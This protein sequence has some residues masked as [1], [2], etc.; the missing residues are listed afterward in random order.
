MT[1]SYRDSLLLP[2]EDFIGNPLLPAEGTIDK[3]R[4]SDGEA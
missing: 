2:V 1:T 3:H 4:S